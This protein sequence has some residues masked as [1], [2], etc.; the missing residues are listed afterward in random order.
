VI[1]PLPG[2]HITGSAEC[3]NGLRPEIP[4]NSLTLHPHGRGQSRLGQYALG[5]RFG[6]EVQAY[7]LPDVLQRLF[8]RPALT[9]AA[10]QLGHIGYV[11]LSLA[12]I[13]KVDQK[14][15]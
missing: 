13:D 6:F 9:H 15:C 11:P 7:G 10:R 4:A 12:I 3:S 1:A 8:D 5:I 2:D 14:S